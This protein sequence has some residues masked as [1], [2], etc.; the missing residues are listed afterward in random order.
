VNKKFFA[1]FL[2]LACA[3]YQL[4]A[5]YK[6]ENG[7]AIDVSKNFNR[8]IIDVFKLNATTT[9]NFTTNVTI[10]IQDLSA[11]MTLDWYIK[12]SKQQY[13]QMQAMILETSDVK[14]GDLS[15]KKLVVIAGGFKFLHVCVV[16]DCKA[17]LLTYTA[18]SNGYEENLA[19]VEKMISSWKFE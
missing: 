1:L 2:C 18:T 12:M 5:T 11:D 3:N 16:K 17:Y 6:S 4:S 7:Y 13:E 15:A 19:E 10:L 8:S 9:E 14:V